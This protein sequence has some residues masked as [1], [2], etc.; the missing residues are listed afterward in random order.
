MK[1]RDVIAALERIAP[2]GLAA[3][4]D[5]VGLLIGDREADVKSLL[6]CIDLTGA[7]LAEVTDGQMVMAYHPVIFKPAAKLT[8]DATPAAYEAARRGLSVFAMHTALDAVAGGTND[9]LAEAMGLVGARPLETAAGHDTCKIVTFVPPKEMANV[10][11]AAFA[12][13]AGQIGDYTDCAFFTHGVGTFLGGEETHPAYGVRGQHEAVEEARLEMIAPLAKA[14][15]VVTAIRAAHSYEEPA[16]DVYRLEQLPDACGQGRVGRLQLAAG[17]QTLIDQIKKALGVGKAWLARPRGRTGRTKVSVAACGAGSCGSLFRQAI[18]AGATFYLT[19]EMRHHDALA[20]TA[21]GLT[22][23]CVG[24]SNSERPTLRP[25]RDRL[26]E[27]L[28]GL[29][30]VISRR[31]ADPFGVV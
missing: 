31:D 12:V 4:W 11:K 26:R 1:V 20:A 19:G 8:A 24:H 17:E 21:E 29:E 9:V 5:N 18:S 23:M 2:S 7:V 6:L 16:V 28:P 3:A 22:V 25:L 27:A 13:G 30:V 15:D 14:G 10:A